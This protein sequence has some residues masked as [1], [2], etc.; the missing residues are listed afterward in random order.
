[1]FVYRCIIL[2]IVFGFSRSSIWAQDEEREPRQDTASILAPKKSLKQWDHGRYTVESMFLLLNTETKGAKF[3]YFDFTQSQKDRVNRG[4][5]S[6][7]NSRK[8]KIEELGDQVS[9][10]KRKVQIDPKNRALHVKLEEAEDQ[11]QEYIADLISPVFELFRK[12]LKPIQFKRLRSIS[13][14]Q[15]TARYLAH[16]KYSDFFDDDHY[17]DWPVWIAESVGMSRSK[18]EKLKKAA[19]NEKEKFGEELKKFLKSYAG[20]LKS[21]KLSTADKQNLRKFKVVFSVRKEKRSRQLLEQLAGSKNFQGQFDISPSQGK[22]IKEILR[23][24]RAESKRSKKSTA[25]K[26]GISQTKQVHSILSKTQKVAFDRR[27]ERAVVRDMLVD[28]DPFYRKIYAESGL[29][30]GSGNLVDDFF[31][32]EIFREKLFEK[33]DRLAN[34]AVKK[35]LKSIPK[36]DRKKVEKYLGER[37][38]LFSVVSKKYRFIQ[39]LIDREQL[40]QDGNLPKL[41]E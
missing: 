28:L 33:R 39:D 8:A 5:E 7:L 21:V 14:Y 40:N 41:K 27:V 12:E 19:K 29:E 17:L 26:L 20:K 4:L 3:K 9:K 1:M 36:S 30:N 11:F 13:C 31:Q 25:A 15:A 16:Y 37:H 18:I 10:F 22:S 2:L 24:F 32:I 34:D 23:K 38:S 6:I 35:I